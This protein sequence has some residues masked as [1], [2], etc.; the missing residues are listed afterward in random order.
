ML[1]SCFKIDQN[2]IKINQKMVSN[3][4]LVSESLFFDFWSIFDKFWT[5]S[6]MAGVFGEN[7]GLEAFPTPKWT[8]KAVWTLLGTVLGPFWKHFGNIFD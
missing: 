6:K 4:K 8:P 3:S 7:L 5:N 1:H 2:F